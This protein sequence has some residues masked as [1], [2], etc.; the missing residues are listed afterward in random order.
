MWDVQASFLPEGLLRGRDR[1]GRHR[2]AAAAAAGRRRDRRARCSTASTASSSPAART[3]TRPATARSR[4]RRPT[5]RAPTATRGRTPCSLPPSTRELPFLGICRG[6]QVLNVALGGTLHQHL[7][8]VVG[9]DRYN[10]GGGVFAVNEVDGRRR[11]AARR[12]SSAASRI[13]VQVAT[14]TRRSTSVGDG[15]VV[16]ARSDDGV[17]QA[18]ELRRRAV[19]CRRAVASRGGRRDDARLFAGLVEAA[20]ELPR[21]EGRRA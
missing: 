21:S 10:A 4:I 13:A 17:I 6:L 11:H 8:D 5:S 16:T 12:R 14:T 3:S 1:G 15:L 2:R 7:P 19:R 18:V 20:R 9:D